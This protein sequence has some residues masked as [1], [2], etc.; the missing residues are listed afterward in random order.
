MR[1]ITNV[2]LEAGSDAQGRVATRIEISELRR[3]LLAYPPNNQGW[4]MQKT[5]IVFILGN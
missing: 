3:T 2:K 4:Y 5:N 1:A